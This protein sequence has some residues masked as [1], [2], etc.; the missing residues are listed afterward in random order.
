MADADAIISRC[1]YTIT[2]VPGVSSWFI[3]EFE[4]KEGTTEKKMRR[5]SSEERPLKYLAKVVFFKI[6]LIF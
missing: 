5:D 4:S 2:N 3:D 6:K 1:C